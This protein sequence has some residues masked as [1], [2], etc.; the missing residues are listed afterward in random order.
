MPD[1]EADIIAG[2]QDEHRAN[3]ERTLDGI[4]AKAEA[5]A[6]QTPRSDSGF[7]MKKRS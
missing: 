6:A 1:R 7:P 3:M 2:R 5:I 4:K